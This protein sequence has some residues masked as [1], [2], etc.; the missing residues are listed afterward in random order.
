M[1]FSSYTEDDHIGKHRMYAAHTQDFRS[2]GP[3]FKYIEWPD[4]VIDTTIIRDRGTFYRFS[5]SNDIQID[6]GP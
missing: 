2:Y 3:V 1:F 6:C 4:H 5:A